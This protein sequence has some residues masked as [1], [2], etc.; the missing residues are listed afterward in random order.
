MGRDGRASLKAIFDVARSPELTAAEVRLWI[1]YRSYEQPDGRGAYPGDELLA[2]H[3]DKS[4]R[5][6][7]GYRARLLK[8]GYLR[9]KLRGPNPAWY[10]AILPDEESQPTA[11]QDQGPSPEADCEASEGSQKASQKGSHKASQPTAPEYGENGEYGEED[12]EGSSLR[13]SSSGDTGAEHS[14]ANDR[15]SVTCLSREQLLAAGPQAVGAR[16]GS[17][18]REHLYTPD[19]RPPKRYSE[20]RDVNIL[21]GLLRGGYRPDCL[22]LA[23]LGVAHE[24]DTGRLDVAGPGEKVTARILRSGVAGRR[25]PVAHF[26]DVGRRLLAG[27]LDPGQL[28]STSR[29]GLSSVGSLLDHVDANGGPPAA[30]EDA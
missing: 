9:Q 12:A 2:K 24:R 25:D 18:L 20:G 1:L 29:E 28:R 19:G 27:E 22:E 30:K 14:R 13:S 7:Q 3:L 23:L 8:L 5:A 21:Q 4:P 16:F 15:R 6:V 26:E 17:L 11:K 10:W